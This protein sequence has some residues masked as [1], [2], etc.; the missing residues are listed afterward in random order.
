MHCHIEIY[1]AFILCFK[2]IFCKKLV[3]FALNHELV[4]SQTLG[5]TVCTQE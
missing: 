4:Q 2:T 5:Q 1:F 3:E